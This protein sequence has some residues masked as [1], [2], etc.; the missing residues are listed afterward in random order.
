MQ[1]S[2]SDH[3]Q[4]L[5]PF[6]QYF[7]MDH[8]PW[9][10]LTLLLLHRSHCVL[11]FSSS[12][13]CFEKSILKL[14]VLLLSANAFAWAIPPCAIDLVSPGAGQQLPRAACPVLTNNP[15][16]VKPRKEECRVACKFLKGA[17]GSEILRGQA[18]LGFHLVARRSP[19]LATGWEVPTSMSTRTCTS[20]QGPQVALWPWGSQ[21]RWGEA[22]RSALQTV[23]G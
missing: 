10:S 13:I 22:P 3:C 4:S 11:T 8:S 6:S 2:D 7:S 21:Q 5:L 15:K 16:R 20:F 17:A 9:K 14:H 23:S 1:L 12:N 19:V 18:C